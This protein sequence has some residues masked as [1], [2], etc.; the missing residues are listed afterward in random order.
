VL[1]CYSTKSW[2]KP[3]SPVL[4]HFYFRPF[5]IHREGIALKTYEM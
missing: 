5:N 1:K 4:L 2:K 3:F